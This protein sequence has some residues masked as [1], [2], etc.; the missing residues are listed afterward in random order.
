MSA[1]TLELSLRYVLTRRQGQAG[2][3]EYSAASSKRPFTVTNEPVRSAVV[4]T[5]LQRSC[6]GTVVEQGIRNHPMYGVRNSAEAIFFRRPGET[7]W[8]KFSEGGFSTLAPVVEIGQIIKWAGQKE[9]IGSGSSRFI[10]YTAWAEGK[11]YLKGNIE[12][13]YLDTAKSG[14]PLNRSGTIDL[15]CVTKVVAAVTW[16][17]LFVTPISN[18]AGDPP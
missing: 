8:A 16:N 12:I 7:P 11:N 17:A 15:T 5:M 9:H 6:K 13:L 14:Q 2:S 18:P 1:A 3:A 4:D 10:E